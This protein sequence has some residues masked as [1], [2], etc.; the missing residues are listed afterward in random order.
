[1]LYRN[2][3]QIKDVVPQLKTAIMASVFPDVGVVSVLDERGVLEALRKDPK[4]ARLKI[5]ED[6]V[7]AALSELI[8]EDKI[9]TVNEATP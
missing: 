4:W 6:L 5:S 8:A 9:T 2:L 7:K 3:N 1:M